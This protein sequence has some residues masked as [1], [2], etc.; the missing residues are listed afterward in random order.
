[1]LGSPLLLGYLPRAP[2]F[3]GILQQSSKFHAGKEQGLAN[4]QT[5]D[6]KLEM[7]PPVTY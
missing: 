1:M 6:F 5:C 2:F 4:L 7:A 3:N